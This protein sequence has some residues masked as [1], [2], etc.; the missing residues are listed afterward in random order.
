MHDDVAYFLRQPLVPALR[1]AA[2]VGDNS[3]AYW[4]PAMHPD[5]T[6]LDLLDQPPLHVERDLE[7]NEKLTTL[8]V[9]AGNAFDTWFN[10]RRYERPVVGRWR[11]RMVRVQP[12]K[13]WEDDI[14]IDVGGALVLVEGL[15][16]HDAG[17]TTLNTPHYK[18]L[19]E[20]EIP[21]EDL[22]GATTRVLGRLS[23]HA[24]EGTYTLVCLRAFPSSTVAS[25]PGP[26]YHGFS[27]ATSLLRAEATRNVV[28][29]MRPCL[30]AAGWLEPELERV[31][32][33]L[34]TA[35]DPRN[36]EEHEAWESA[37]EETGHYF[38]TGF[39]ARA[40][41]PSI[42]DDRTHD[43]QPT[44]L[45]APRLVKGADAAEDYAAELLRHLGFHDAV[46]TPKG[47]DGGTDVMASGVVVQ[48]KFE[49]LPTGRP[50]IQN[51]AG[52]AAVEDARA[53]FFSLAGYTPAAIA[54]ADRARVALLEFEVDGTIMAT[55]Q[56]GVALLSTGKG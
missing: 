48:V 47:P 56:E 7:L 45:P 49:A 36:L 52:I 42:S 51:L 11:T 21:L 10:E 38:W 28:A 37:I 18:Y 5:A 31:L 12:S 34:T 9:I 54:W 13:H 26:V 35:H 53:V 46:R 30:I 43:N 32:W 3:L 2:P 50:A 44:G 39:D 8:H 29:S 19:V 22:W 41:A 6:V 40:P 16:T 25:R 55:N 15:L 4:V 33:A 24:V 20:T 1:A 14:D 17:M 27:P 23:P